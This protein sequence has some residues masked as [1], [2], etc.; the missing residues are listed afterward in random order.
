VPWPDSV[1]DAVLRFE[2]VKRETL[3][4]R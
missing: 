1:K 3:P 4:Q 2:A